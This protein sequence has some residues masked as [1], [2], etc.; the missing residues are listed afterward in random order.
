[1]IDKINF[2]HGKNY[3]EFILFALKNKLFLKLRILYLMGENIN[4]Y[5]WECSAMRADKDRIAIETMVGWKLGK[6]ELK[7]A[8]FYLRGKN[9]P[10]FIS[11]FY[12]NILHS[13]IGGAGYEPKRMMFELD[14]E[15][16]KD[17]TLDFNIARNSEN[18]VCMLTK[19]DPDDYKGEEAIVA[20]IKKLAFIAVDAKTGSLKI[21][22]EKEVED[23]TADNLFRYNTIGC[24]SPYDKQSKQRAR[25]IMNR[26]HEI[27]RM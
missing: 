4:I 13:V 17:I 8:K 9:E 3:K 26:I 25:K 12:E 22:E 18:I 7:Y 19:Y 23:I 16:I 6:N 15:Q 5:F 11:L 2:Y 20:Q 27:R 24:V 21:L 14:E 10:N 1:M